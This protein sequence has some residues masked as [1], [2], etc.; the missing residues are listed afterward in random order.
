MV[1]R[2]VARSKGS[3]AKRE[4]QLPYRDERNYKDQKELQGTY[5]MAEIVLNRMTKCFKVLLLKI[6]QL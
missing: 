3:K 6:N 2:K 4:G 1:K 5:T